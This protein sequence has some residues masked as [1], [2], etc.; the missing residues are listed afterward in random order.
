MKILPATTLALLL[1]VCL[2][3]DSGLAQAVEEID[4]G[5]FTTRELSLK[6]TYGRGDR[7]VIQSVE[8]LRGTIRVVADEVSDIRA[9]YTKQARAANRSL[10]IDYIDRIGV[11][12]TPTPTGA[13]I[14]LRAPN[15]PPWE[16][17][18]DAGMVVIDVVVPLNSSI[19]INARLFD[20][21]IVGPLA[22]VSVMESL[23][24]IKVQG[25]TRRLDIATANRRVTIEDVTGDVFVTTSNSLLEAYNVQCDSGRRADFRNDEGDIRIETF[26]GEMTVRNSYG[27]ID[28]TGVS[29]LGS[30]NLVRSAYGPIYLELI[31]ITD[32][33]IKL[34]NRQEDI[35]V[36]M[37]EDLS[38][39]LSLAVEEDSRIEVSNF[40]MQPELIERNRLSMIV[41]GSESLISGSVSGKG[42]IFVRGYSRKE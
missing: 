33:Q 7:L 10:A 20:V 5:L 35:E 28:L 6:E 8:S 24:R 36:E 3:I 38:V 21:E 27:R 41:G 31:D 16:V 39:V 18:R 34:S 26:S 2:G 19:E 22:E 17:D 37:P 32:A 40:T 29:L 11:T 4:D 12:S 13:E 23:G 15:P 25:V 42:N 30:R 9:D 14:S 1:T